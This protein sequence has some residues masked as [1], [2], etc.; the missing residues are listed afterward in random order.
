[1][2]LSGIPITDDHIHI[3]PE[4][5]GD[6]GREGLPAQRGTYLPRLKALLVVCIEPPPA[7]HREVFD[8]PGLRRWSARPGLWSIRSSASTRQR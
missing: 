2:K 4:T 5:A 7:K 6:R 3:D 8:N 1:M